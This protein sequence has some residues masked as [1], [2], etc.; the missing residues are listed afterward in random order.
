MDE[1]REKLR[2]ATNGSIESFNKHY[3]N[4]FPRH[5]PGL[6]EWVETTLQEGQR[7]CAVIK[8]QMDSDSF[9]KVYPCADIMKVPRSYKSFKPPVKKRAYNAKKIARTKKSKIDKFVSNL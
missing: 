3:G 7:W 2:N 9:F 1:E 8:N 6:L 4:L 5:H